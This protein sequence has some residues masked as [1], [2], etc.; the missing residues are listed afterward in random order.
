MAASADRTVPS[1]RPLAA[2]ALLA[3][4]FAVA[5]A[6]CGADDPAAA[7][8]ETDPVAGSA[9]GGETF[10]FRATTDENARSATFGWTD[11]FTPTRSGRYEIVAEGIGGYRPQVLVRDPDSNLVVRT[12]EFS[13]RG[14]VIVDTALDAGVEYGIW[15]W[16]PGPRPGMA[17]IT[18][19]PA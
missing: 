16:E 12:P 18:I 19:R 5:A 17:N 9:A 13:E 7:V 14:Y 15:V 4:L 6:G 10:E 3:A 2:R 8:A 11:T 1:R